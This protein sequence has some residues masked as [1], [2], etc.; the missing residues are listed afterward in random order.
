ML[1]GLLL[2]LLLVEVAEVVGVLEDIFIIK[3]QDMSQCFHHLKCGMR[4][5]VEGGRQLGRGPYVLLDDGILRDKGTP[6]R[7]N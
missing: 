1:V 2:N 5:A 7:S 3:F 4:C 6:G